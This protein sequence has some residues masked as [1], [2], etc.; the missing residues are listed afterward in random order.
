MISLKTGIN[1][2]T[3]SKKTPTIISISQK[4]FNP[5]CTI[6]ERKNVNTFSVGSIVKY[7]KIKQSKYI[8]RSLKGLK[9]FLNFIKTILEKFYLKESNKCFIFNLSGVGY[10]LISLKKI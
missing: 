7:F 8:R 3:P 4:D 2:I 6:Y 9:I 5:K 10:N 1:K